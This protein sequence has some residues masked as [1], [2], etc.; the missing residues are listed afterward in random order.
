MT[1]EPAFSVHVHNQSQALNFFTSHNVSL[2]VS[3]Y[4]DNRVY[5]FGA[6]DNGKISC[7]PSLHDRPM[8]LASMNGNVW[9]AG[10]HHLIRCA[11]VGPEYND[12]E[13]GKFTTTYVPRQLFALGDQDIHGIYPSNDP[14][15]P[16]FV[17]TKF[18][19]LCQLDPTKPTV[20]N[21]VVWKPPFITEIRPEDRCHLNDVCFIDG[22]PRYA[23]CV[24]ESDAHD[25]WRDHRQE[26]GVIVDV[27]TGENY[28]T[29][30]SMPHSPRW[31]KNQL[32]LLNSGTGELGVI[33]EGK[34]EAKVFLPGFLRGL[35]FVGRF[36][37]VGS[38]LDRHEK[39]FQDLDL[40]KKLETKK[41]S[42]ICGLYIVDLASFSI[43]SKIELCG[44]MV[45]ELYDVCVVPGKRARVMGL[46]DVDTKTMFVVQEPEAKKEIDEQE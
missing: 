2:V 42:P 17:A 31:Y 1:E 4:K 44:K 30:L 5:S 32:W 36:A 11:P 13:N 26:G 3:S 29:G 16:Y 27:Q 6:T 46:N 28:A 18:S 38:S 23:S 45:H 19:A 20:T 15:K 8:A 43:T 22:V 35:A 9:L 39:R 33:N 12:D 14:N 21:N 7:W 24:C 10:Q 40:G 41:T 34:F 25:G 37:I